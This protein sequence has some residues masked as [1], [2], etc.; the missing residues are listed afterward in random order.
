M[1]CREAVEAQAATSGRASP[2]RSTR[3][4]QLSPHAST[5]A[6]RVHQLDLW[7]HVSGR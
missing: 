2:S 3:G 6:P 5:A 1:L 7:D 4:E